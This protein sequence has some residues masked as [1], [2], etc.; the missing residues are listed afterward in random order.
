[1]R[2]CRSMWLMGM[3]L[4]LVGC[5]E[6]C[7]RREPFWVSS[8]CVSADPCD[9][10]IDVDVGGLPEQAVMAGDVVTVTATVSNL[11]GAP[12]ELV[13]EDDCPDGA[14]RFTGLP[15]EDYDYY[16][17]CGADACV[18]A[19]ESRTDLLAFG[20]PWVIEL[21][22]DL[23]VGECND[24]V[25]PGVYELEAVL[26]LVDEADLRVCTGIGILHVL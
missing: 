19:G 1:M 26:P 15:D 6:V 18:D 10:Q 20:E 24:A 25:E 11:T 4:G 13:L 22:L 16:G 9:V 5:H 2:V 23:A 7:G 3:V 21:T 14:V 17:Q 8:Y 12:L